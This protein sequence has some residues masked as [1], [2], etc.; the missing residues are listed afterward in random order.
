MKL[1]ELK[2]R[3]ITNIC[4]AKDSNELIAILLESPGFI[5]ANKDPAV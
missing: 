4:K 3:I 1:P 2:C 5:K